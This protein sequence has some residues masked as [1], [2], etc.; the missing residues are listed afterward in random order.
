MAAGGEDLPKIYRFPEFFDRLRSRGA[1]DV[2]GAVESETEIDGVLYHH[3]GAQIPGHNLMFVWEP[4]GDHPQFSI[5]LDTV[6]SRSL[7]AVFDARRSWDVYLM[8]YEGGALVAWMTDSEFEA[9]EASAL[10][11][12][13][14][15]VKAGRFSFGTF[16]RFGP[17][18]VEV[19]NWALESTAPAIIQTHTGETVKP[20]TPEEYF[21]YMESIP[22]ELRPVDDGSPPEYLGLESIEL[23][24]GDGPDQ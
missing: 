22:L 13:T 23:S 17:D 19:E 6:G 10:P 4:G 16:F 5:E 12:K 2:R 24:V 15:A 7:W 8:L 21:S 20:D 14:A 18:W 1:L 11:S 3:R 9:E